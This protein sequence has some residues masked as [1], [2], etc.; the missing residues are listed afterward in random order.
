MH[1]FAREGDVKHI[2]ERCMLIRFIL[3]ERLRLLGTPGCWDHLTQ[4]RGLY[5]CTGLN[6][7]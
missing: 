1:V 7:E 4:Q 5:C 3:K 2:V 6:G